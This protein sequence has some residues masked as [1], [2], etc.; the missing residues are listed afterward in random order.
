MKKSPLLTSLAANSALSSARA[1]FSRAV[2][3]SCRTFQVINHTV[4]HSW[5]PFL[6]I[7]SLPERGRLVAVP[8][9]RLSV[10]ASRQDRQHVAWLVQGPAETSISFRCRLYLTDNAV[11]PWVSGSREIILPANCWSAPSHAAVPCCVG[12]VQ[13]PVPVCVSIALSS[14]PSYL[15]DRVLAEAQGLVLR[16]FQV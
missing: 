6:A 2:E 9:L 14:G 11:A 3:L 16:R 15:L 13:H 10:R 7:L 4:G 5:S 12:S 8:A 1:L